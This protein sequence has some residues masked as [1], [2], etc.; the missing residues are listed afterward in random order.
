MVNVT[1]HLK[2]LL[3]FG[4]AWG[5]AEPHTSEIDY[6]QMGIDAAKESFKPKYSYAIGIIIPSPLH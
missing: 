4:L 1:K 5:Q 3:L 2:L 6:Y